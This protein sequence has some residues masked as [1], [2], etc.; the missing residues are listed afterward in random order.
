MLAGAV[1]AVWLVAL[2]AIDVGFE[3]RTRGRIADRIA[4]A[5]Q[6]EATI[7]HGDLALVRGAIDLAGLAVR[8]D[9][10]IGHLALTVVDLHCELRPLGLALVDRDCRELTVRGTRLSVSTAALFKLKR[11]KRPPLHALHVVIDDARFEL[12]PSA[13]VPSLGRVAVAIE[14]AEAGETIFKTPLSWLFALRALHATI[15]LPAGITL[16]LTYELGQ[17]RVAGGIFGATPVE[18]PVALPVADLADDPRAELARLIAF[19]KDI[20]ERVVSHK[21]EDWLKTKLSLP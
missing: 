19:G 20:A 9:D 18:L 3:G 11:A 10:L 4:E 8:R 12:S 2:V 17:L 14:H 21:A 16:R 7:D 1:A 5:L 15:E 6:A 13:L